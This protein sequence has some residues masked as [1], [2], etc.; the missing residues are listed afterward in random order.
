MG[1]GPIYGTEVRQNVAFAWPELFHSDHAL[2][3]TYF[4]RF[5]LKCLGLFTIQILSCAT[6]VRRQRLLA[7]GES[8][9]EIRP[10]ARLDRSFLIKTLLKIGVGWVQRREPFSGCNS[11]IAH[12]LTTVS[13]DKPRCYLER[14]ARGRLAGAEPSRPGCIGEYVNP[15]C[16][17]SI[18]EQTCVPRKNSCSSSTR[19]TDRPPRCRF[20]CAHHAKILAD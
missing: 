13:L 18:Q 19:A 20:S 6:M 15:H 5:P 7:A 14:V 9:R 12:F 17:I 8:Y 11:I 3:S 2:Q 1:K 16:C 4:T 10:R